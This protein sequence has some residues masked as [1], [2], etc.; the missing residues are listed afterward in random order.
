MRKRDLPDAFM[1]FSSSEHVTSTGTILPLRI[2]S[3]ISMPNSEPSRDRSSRSRSPADKWVN[4]NRSTI[5]EHCVPFPAPGPPRTNTTF[6]FSLLMMEVVVMYP[7]PLEC[8]N[9]CCV[10]VNPL[11]PQLMDTVTPLAA[12]AK[13]RHIDYWG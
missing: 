10:S 11:G 13:A 8:R 5:L 3:S 9:S 1:A 12:C 7:L 6:G 2:Y 4:W